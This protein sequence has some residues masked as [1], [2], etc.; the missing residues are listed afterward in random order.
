MENK[1]GG[2]RIDEALAAVDEA[3]PG[4]AVMSRRSFA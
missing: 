1:K 2:Y 3:A 4:A